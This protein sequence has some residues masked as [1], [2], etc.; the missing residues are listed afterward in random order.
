MFSGLLKSAWLNRMAARAIGIYLDLALRSTRWTVEGGANL[1]PYL[2][3]GAVIVAVWHERLP[4]IPALWASARFDN[5]GRRVSALASRHRDGR[6]IAGVMARFGLRVVHGSSGRT[7]P[8]AAARRDHG[9]AA[10]MRGLI[11]ALAEGDAV[12]ITP[13]GPRGPRRV[14]APGVAQLAAVTGA[15]VLAVAGQVR[16]RVTL[17]SWDRMVLPLPLGR[18]ALVCLPVI[19][20]AP[21]G[22]EAAT[23]AIGAAMSRALARADLLCG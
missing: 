11:G 13:D 21:E 6:F 5:P 18:G 20:V 23:G 12:V 9:G 7:K 19:R 17:A 8:G 4:V 22:A 2:S 3:D 14:A 16:W 15:P 10:G 1:A